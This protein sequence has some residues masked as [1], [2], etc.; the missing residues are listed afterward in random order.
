MLSFLFLMPHTPAG[1]THTRQ[2]RVQM[3]PNGA[4]GPTHHATHDATPET[5]GRNRRPHH[6]HQHQNRHQTHNGH[7]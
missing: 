5:T 2:R 6:P 7:S 1:T 3:E 4:I